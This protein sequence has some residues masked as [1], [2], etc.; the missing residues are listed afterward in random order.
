GVIAN[1]AI[2]PCGVGARVAADPELGHEVGQHAEELVPVVVALVDQR[3][4]LVH[5]TGCP[6][7][8]RLDDDASLAGFERDQKRVRCGGR[9][10]AV[11]L[12]R[13]LGRWRALTRRRHRRKSHGG[14][15][16]GKIVHWSQGCGGPAVSAS[17]TRSRWWSFR[18]WRIAIR[19]TEWMSVGCA[20]MVTGDS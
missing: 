15:S 9:D 4:E 2:L 18:L 20:C 14:E 1:H 3:E 10:R 17:A 12:R 16:A 11:G 7:A 13:L 8:H 6:R 19:F 5:T